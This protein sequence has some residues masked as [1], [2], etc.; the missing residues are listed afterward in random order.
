[1]ETWAC[2]FGPDRMQ[3]GKA[4]AMQR[5][6][7]RKIRPR[8]MLTTVPSDG[9]VEQSLASPMPIPLAQQLLHSPL[10][11]LDTVR[12]MLLRHLALANSDVSEAMA[13]LYRTIE[14]P[15]R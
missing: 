14:A 10:R 2:S 9:S 5:R 7:H 4:C 1:M 15:T 12:E 11:T 8:V 6:L 13:R 3:D